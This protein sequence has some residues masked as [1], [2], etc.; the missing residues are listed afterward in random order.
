MREK[1]IEYAKTILEVGVN[2]KEGQEVFINA[3]TEY[4]E[5]LIVLVEEA[6]KLKAKKVVI[7]WADTDLSRLDYK[8]CDI[9]VLESV[10]DYVIK[11]Y[12][13]IVENG[14]CIISL[15][16][17]AS[18]VFSGID[19]IKIQKTRNAFSKA[20]SKFYTAMMSDKLT[21]C[22][23]GVP[24]RRWAKEVFPNLLEEEAYTKLWETI[25]Y[26]SRI[27]VGKSV[28][29]WKN[30]ISLLKDRA[31][32]LNNYNFKELHYKAS[33]GTDF[34]VGLP[35]G[36]IWVAAESENL[37]N[38][39]KFTAN[40][41]TEEIYTLPDRNNINGKIY[42]TKVL[43]YNGNAISDFWFEV[44]NGKVINFDAR[45]GKDILEKLLDSDEGS[46][47]FGEVA[48]VPYNSPI[49]NTNILFYNT[50]YDENAS[51]HF[52]LGRAYPT[53]LDGGVDMTEEELVKNGANYSINHVDFMIGSNDLSI[54]G[55]TYTGEK[56]SIF[57]NGNFSELF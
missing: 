18:N 7:N 38:N 47:Y 6:Y 45:E 23:A 21:W 24:T 54:V 2:L 17:Q 27:E 9:D 39:R 8:Y 12:D 25:F 41:P 56:I 15:T 20:V 32:K 33:N 3:L 48:L 36:H 43:N 51:C 1:Y 31:K 11:R 42:S 50:L 5:F 30:H 13:T 40:I 14:A 29:N 49:S 34:I 44:K 35:K 10:E 28:E 16:G 46:R 37:L 53:T 57:E 26:V 22:V 52:A 55:T 4:R 19:A